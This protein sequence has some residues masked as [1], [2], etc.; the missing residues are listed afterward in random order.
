MERNVASQTAVRIVVLINKRN[1][2]EKHKVSMHFIPVDYIILLQAFSFIYKSNVSV[3][4]AKIIFHGQLLSYSINIS[5]NYCK[6]SLLVVVSV[7]T[8]HCQFFI[9]SCDGP[10]IKLSRLV[11]RNLFAMRTL[12]APVYTD[13]LTLLNFVELLQNR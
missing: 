5:G 7:K 2:K 8:L 12:I 13:V 3:I 10:V 1:I 11:V 6:V 4:R 9:L